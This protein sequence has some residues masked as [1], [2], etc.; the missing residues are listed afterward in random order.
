MDKLWVVIRREYLERVRS[1]WFLI[2]TV[3]GPL[4]FSALLFLPPWLAS[5]SAASLDLARVIIIDGTGGDLGHRIAAALNGGVNADTTATVVRAVAPA[6]LRSAESRAREEVLAGRTRGFLLLDSTALS[7]GK[8][9]YAGENATS[10]AD[11]DRLAQILRA[12]LLTVRLERA[13]LDPL[14]S[15]ALA[16]LRVSVDAQRISRRGGTS[17]A[18]T[19][20]IAAFGLAM[21]LYAAIL[22]Y[23]QNVM[24]GVLEEKQ[25][26]VAEVVVSS[27]P[28]SKLLAG[29]VLGVGAVGLTQMVI[30]I[31]SSFALIK[32]RTPLLGLGT[33]E[34]PM[35]F[36]SLTVWSAVV[37]LLFFTLGY[38]LYAALFAAIGAAVSTEQDAQQAQIP[39]VLLLVA[40]VI[41]LPPI[42]AA[43]DSGLAYTFGWLP[44]SAPIVMPLRMA[45]VQLSWFDITMSL[46]VLAA[47]CYLAVWVA[48]RIYR[49]GLLMYGKR[50]SLRELGR[51]V[52]AE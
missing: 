14:Q 2:A 9:T 5:R 32:L 28:S 36:G 11:M 39:V 26:R 16:S 25:T 22:M 7:T 37:L 17:S 21:L 4:L 12:Q 31:A 42:L 6:Q 15:S 43:P 20:I 38:T 41:M 33:A 10:T 45:M 52:R 40:S 34:A 18:R 24:R 19:T 29:K 3:F 13:G 35:L 30:W 49:V 50:P 47:S 27:I 8:V 48:A 51:W 46:I 44:F 23:G 1:R